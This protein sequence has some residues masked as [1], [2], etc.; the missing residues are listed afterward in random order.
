MLVRYPTGAGGKFLISSLFLFDHIAHWKPEV[1]DGALPYMTWFEHAWPDQVT[2]WLKVEPNQPWHLDFYSRRFNRN[3]DL[4][5]SSFNCM[6][7]D[8]ASEYFHRCW[9]HGF[10]IVDHWHKRSVPQFFSNATVIE[11]TLDSNSLDAYKHCVKNKVFIWDN[12][13]RVVISTMDHPDWAW[14]TKTRQ[15]I[16]HFKNPAELAEFDD[17]DD[18]FYGYLLDKPWVKPFYQS[19]PDPR[20]LFSWNFNTLVDRDGYLSIMD[21]LSGHWNQSLDTD[22]LC[23]MHDIW[24]NKTQWRPRSITMPQRKQA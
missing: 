4:D 3:N 10:T 21:T 5:K 15:N 22:Q 23:R 11:I 1:Q 24:T 8:Q 2:E 16:D 9:Q 18:F 17:Y 7:R 14:N 20:C 12:D 13:R 6:V 19:V